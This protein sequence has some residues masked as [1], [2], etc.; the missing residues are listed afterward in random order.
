M[1]GSGHNITISNQPWLHDEE[2]PFVSS[3]SLSFANNIVDSLMVPNERRWDDDIIRDLFN[4]RDQQCIL[5]TPLRQSQAEDKLFWCKENSGLVS[6]KSVYK[7]LQE[8]KGV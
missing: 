3:T 1:V 5:N 2:N 4:E 8:Q 7:L 6:V